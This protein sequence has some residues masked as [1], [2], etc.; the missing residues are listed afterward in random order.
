M[1]HNQSQRAH[2][3]ETDH[4]YSSSKLMTFLVNN[5]I[6]F[7]TYYTPNKTLLFFAEKLWRDFVVQKLL[8]LFQQ[9]I[10]VHLILCVL[11]DFMNPKLL[12]SISCTILHES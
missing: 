4:E 3:K 10:L 12:I 1:I 7:Q 11:E 2:V 8:T 6:K 9:N 5:T